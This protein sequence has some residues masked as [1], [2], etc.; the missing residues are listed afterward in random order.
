[1]EEIKNKQLAYE[2]AE[3]KIVHHGTGIYKVRCELM[4]KIT[5]SIILCVTMIIAAVCIT[6]YASENVIETPIIRVSQSEPTPPTPPTPPTDQNKLS[7]N[8][9]GRSFTVTASG[10]NAGEGVITVA[11]YD[12][13]DLTRLL[14]VKT[15]ESKTSAS[16]DFKED[17]YAKAFWWSSLDDIMPLCDAEEGKTSSTQSLTE[18]ERITEAR[19]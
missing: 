8:I 3:L 14:D 13:K 11:L 4:K 2:E 10:K 15:F 7:L 5:V 6:A 9:T 17:G 16:G 18:T 12:S 19:N 1:M